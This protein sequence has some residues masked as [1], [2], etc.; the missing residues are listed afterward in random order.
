MGASDRAMEPM[1][2]LI[3]LIDEDGSPDSLSPLRCGLLHC[4][5]SVSQ[6]T[7]RVPQERKGES[8]LNFSLQPAQ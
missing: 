6:N 8:H 7:H 5:Q 3:L 2:S 1:L 4:V